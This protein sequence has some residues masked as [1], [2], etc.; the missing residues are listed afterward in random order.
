MRAAHRFGNTFTEEPV[1]FAQRCRL[2]FRRL[3]SVKLDAS[4]T[5]NRSSK[6]FIAAV[7]LAAGYGVASFVGSPHAPYLPQVSQSGPAALQRDREDSPNLGANA[8]AGVRLLPEV[9][10]TD[11]LP[12]VFGER[13]HFSRSPSLPYPTTSASHDTFDLITSQLP[14]TAPP[15]APDVFTVPAKRYDEAGPPPVENTRLGLQA[16]FRDVPPRAVKQND[17]AELSTTPSSRAAGIDRNVV[18]PPPN[19]AG[20]RPAAAASMAEIPAS[21]VAP[22]NDLRYPAR[23]ATL[24]PLPVITPAPPK[25]HTIVDGDSLPRLAQRYLNDPRRSDE[26][27]ALNRDVLTSPDLLPI[28]VELKVP[29]ITATARGG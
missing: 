4:V 10:A 1:V 20:S 11:N 12:L 15:N 27:F 14:P 25:L 28:G 21:Y 7:I 26:I 19:F 22:A 3:A 5:V 29:A 6:L 24:A 8:A 9:A 13:D 23:I 2:A 18:G 16:R 17:G